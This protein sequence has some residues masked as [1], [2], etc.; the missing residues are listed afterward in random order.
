MSEAT[1]TQKDKLVGDL[2]VVI[3]DTEEL[4]RMTAD[5]VGESANELRGRL[6]ER[7]SQ[8]RVHLSHAQEAA[9]ARAKAA[10]LATDEY[11]HDHPWNSIGVAAGIGFLIGL[12]I[13]RR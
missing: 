13:S 8:A 10:G 12:L 2:K 5:E 7:L 6:Q 3:S 1:S 9:V 4:L 11:V